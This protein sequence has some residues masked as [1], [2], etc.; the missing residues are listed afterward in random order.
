MRKVYRIVESVMRDEVGGREGKARQG[1]ERKG[2]TRQGKEMQY[3]ARE[4]KI[5]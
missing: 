3:R 2:M 4:G 5:W 1:K